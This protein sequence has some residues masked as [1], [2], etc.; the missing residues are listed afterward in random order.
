[1]VF[2]SVMFMYFFLPCVLLLYYVSPEKFKNIIIL[3][4]GLFFYAWG[5]PVHIFLMILSIVFNYLVGMDIENKKQQGKNAK[6]VFIF[7]LIFNLFSLGFF[8]YSGFIVNNINSI[9]RIIYLI[10]IFVS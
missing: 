6:A 8:K 5:E 10:S 2:S 3:A 4:S 1:M 9:F 7:C